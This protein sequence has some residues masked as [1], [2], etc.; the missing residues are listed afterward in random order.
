MTLRI[1][2]YK[3]FSKGAKALSLRCGILRATKKQYE[4]MVRLIPC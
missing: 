2:P 4:S 1:E 3:A